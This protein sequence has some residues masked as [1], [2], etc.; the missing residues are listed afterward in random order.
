MRLALTYAL[1]D[2]S[3]HIDVVHLQAALAVWNYCERSARFIFGDSLGEKVA[4]KILDELRCAGSRGLTL[5][6]IRELFRRNLRTDKM[7]EAL[8]LLHRLKLA[9]YSKEPRGRGRPATVWRTVSSSAKPA[10][11][12]RPAVALSL[13]V[14]DDKQPKSPP[15]TESVAVPESNVPK[16][17]PLYV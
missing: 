15:E 16:V 11:M 17:D 1:L 3:P 4:D 6:K 9:C 13:P 2:C 5:D 7:Q 8:A 14:S 12:E 10:D